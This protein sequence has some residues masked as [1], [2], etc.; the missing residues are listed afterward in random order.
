MRI[1]QPPIS[2]KRDRFTPE[3]IAQAVRLQARFDLSLRK[4]KEFLRQRGLD[5]SCETV[6]RLDR[7]IRPANCPW[8]SPQTAATLR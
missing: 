3:I 7:Q 8:F 1:T 6:R 2:Y 5:V 4:E